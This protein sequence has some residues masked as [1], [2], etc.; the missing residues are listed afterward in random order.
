MATPLS[1]AHCQVNTVS[2]YSENSLEA[3]RRAAVLA[4]H[5]AAPISLLSVVRKDEDRNAVER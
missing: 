1:E 5:L 3:A 4:Q 2:V